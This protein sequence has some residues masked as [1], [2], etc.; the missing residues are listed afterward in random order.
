MRAIFLTD[1]WLIDAQNKA[2]KKYPAQKKVLAK[3]SSARLEE[4]AMAK[5]KYPTI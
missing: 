5:N 3:V 1:F 4:G 2:R